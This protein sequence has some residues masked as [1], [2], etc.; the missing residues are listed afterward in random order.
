VSVY[1]RRSVALKFAV[2]AGLEAR[3]TKKSVGNYE[4]RSES[5]IR[6]ESFEDGGV[7]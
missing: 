3:T 2:L 7:L 6:K 4:K 1:D 5:G